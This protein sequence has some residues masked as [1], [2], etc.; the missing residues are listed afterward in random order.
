[1]ILMNLT[2]GKKL[3][4]A[5][6]LFGLLILGIGLVAY[7]QLEQQHR[8]TQ[9]IV[10]TLLPNIQRASA[11][12]GDI[13]SFRRYQLGLFMV[14]DDPT[15]S[16]EYRQIL[17]QLQQRI[18]SALSLALLAPDPTFHRQIQS[19][20]QRYVAQHQQ[21]MAMLAREEVNPAR[22]FLNQGRLA[23]QALNSEI[24]ALISANQKLAEQNKIHAQALFER[25]RLALLACSTLA[26]LLVFVFAVLLTQQIRR[27]LLL[28]VAQAK[29]IAQGDLTGLQLRTQLQSGKM[30]QDEITALAQ[31]IA[32]MQENLHQLVNEI[33]SSVAQLGGAVTQVST[34][35]KHAAHG[36]QQQQSEVSQL[37]AAMNEM[38][39]T[40]QEVSRNTTDAA[41]A[42]QQA[43]S[44]S[45]TGSQVVHNTITSIE[46][47][48]AEI[49]HSGHVVQLLEQ[50]SASISVVLDVIR[51]IADQTNLLA[52]NAAIE[53]ARAGEQ[54]RGFAVVADEVRTLARRTQD[55]TAEINKIIEVLQS[56]AA[57][58]GQAMQVSRQQMH[59]SVE[60]ARNAGATI[61]QINQAV[62][63]ISDMNT[64]IASATEQQNS[65]TDELNRSIVT[66]HNA[67]D[68]VA[69][70]ANQTAQACAELSQ[71]AIHLQQVTNRF[72][73]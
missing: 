44:A 62:A 14:Y 21:M 32:Q 26:I 15:L 45:D 1:M 50:D 6:S 60:Q 20:W 23:Y 48:A 54:G 34:V 63:R 17:Q 8:A 41:H 33:A 11:L 19:N 36:M 2:I 58:A 47:V 64:Q 39:S 29:Q 12:S 59:T 5:F 40:V 13:G 3:T 57:E 61:A 70:G 51:N 18:D 56:R 49:E 35:A 24:V 9:N 38:Q 30:P 7:T 65:V 16:T 10:D 4:S 27:P 71:L 73:V 43:S 67:S 69:Q 72:A 25:T 55:S 66:I 68:D 28:L 22:H 52:L 31:T 42:A 37:A 46:R 53:A